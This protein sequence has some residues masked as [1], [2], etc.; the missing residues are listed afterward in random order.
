MRPKRKL[1]HQPM[2]YRIVLLT[3]VLSGIPFETIAEEQT[4]IV[5]AGKHARLDTPIS[6]AIP[7]ALQKYRHFTLSRLDTDKSVAVQTVLGGKPT[8]MWILKDPLAAGKTRRYR[9]APTDRTPA[10]KQTVA[11]DDDGKQLR[12]MVAGK[13]VLVYNAAVVPSPDRKTSY[14]DRSGYIH[15]I[16]NP[17][18]Q[19]LTDDFAPDHPHQ[20][21]VMFPWTNTTFEGRDINFW[22][23]QKQ[24]ATVKHVAVESSVSGSVFGEF[25]AKLHH[26]DITSP[27]KPKVALAETWHVRIYNTSNGFLFDLKSRQ[28]AVSSPLQ[29][30]QYHYG[31]MAI[32][33]HR[34]WLTPGQGDFLTNEGKTRKNGNHS[35][36]HWVDVHGFVDGKTTG[37][38]IFCDPRNFRSP[39]PVR[40]HPSK[41]YFCF[42]PMV[43]GG[44]AITSDK[45]YISRYRFFVHDGKLDVK[46]AEQLW[47]DLVDP[48]QVK[49]TFSTK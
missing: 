14:Y 46:V 25:T 10:T 32:R 21:G 35:R 5:F 24:R 6:V 31:A 8:L 1:W 15:P 22:D 28:Q 16:Y 42:A 34:N 49:I 45:P 11:I 43:L 12:V 2:L 7:D 26:V 9:L 38:T 40:L 17:S 19:A 3:L 27:D 48:P 41:P 44:F 30:K 33:G 37:V 4:V 20:H 23:Q 47:N 18:G 13:P 39:Q 29:I 36:P